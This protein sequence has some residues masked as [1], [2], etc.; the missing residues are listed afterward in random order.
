MKPY[1]GAIVARPSPEWLEE[2]FV[3]RAALEG[4]ALRTSIP[5][6]SQEDIDN[7]IEINEAM[8]ECTKAGDSME[9]SRLN[10]KFHRAIIGKC[11]YPNLLNLID[12]F[13]MMS[14]FGRAIFGLNPKAMDV[15]DVEHEELIE[16]IQNRDAD[17]GEMINRNH[18]L[19]VGQELAR[20]IRNGQKG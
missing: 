12:D 3:I 14:Q 16:A 9:Y 13:L 17:K 20:I 4:M 15:S 6:L 5:R 2:M 8:G 1:I 19:W 18:R 11:P 10:R 7:I